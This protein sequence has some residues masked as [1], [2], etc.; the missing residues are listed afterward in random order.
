VVR[1]WE[2]TAVL[3]CGLKGA[4][5]VVSMRW[6]KSLG[7]QATTAREQEGH[8]LRACARRWGRRVL[9]LV[10]RGEAS[11]AVVGGIGQSRCALCDALAQTLPVVR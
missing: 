3:L 1:G 8:L 11:R 10:A 5:Q 6:W 4:V 7:E 9:H 2:W